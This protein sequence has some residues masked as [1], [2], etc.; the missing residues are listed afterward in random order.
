MRLVW[1]QSKFSRS[2]L[3]EDIMGYRGRGPNTGELW[4]REEIDNLKNT[5]LEKN[6]EFLPGKYAQGVGRT[7]RAITTRLICMINPLDKLFDLEFS[8]KVKKVFPDQSHN[9]ILAQI[10][11][12]RKTWG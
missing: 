2:T 5:F 1:F 4:T 9:S 7:S 6:K 11:N 3:Y 12:T 10:L 8:K